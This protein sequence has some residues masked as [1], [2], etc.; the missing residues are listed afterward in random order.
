MPSPRTAI[1]E[2]DP[3]TGVSDTS[4]GRPYL[5]LPIAAGGTS[6]P[7][8]IRLDGQQVQNLRLSGLTLVK[9]FTN[10]IT[11]WDDPAITSDNDGHALPSL[12][13]TPVVQA[14]GSGAT[15]QLTSYFAAEFPSIWQSYS[16]QAGMTEYYPRQGNQIAQNGS[17]AAMNYVASSQANGSISYVEYSFS[18]PLSVKTTPSKLCSPARATTPC[19]PNTT[20]RSPW[21]TPRSTRIPAPPTTLLQNLSNV[22]T[23]PGIHAPTPFP[24]IVYM[25]EPT[26]RLSESGVEDHDGQTPVDR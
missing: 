9:I 8:Q 10:Q 4:Q 2:W 7:Y 22:Y 19:R 12:P 17:N 18:R 20:W 25:I 11:N 15:A 1:R 24:R 13:I 6:F 16:G 21:R 3:V 14:E 5:Y 26:G 23:D